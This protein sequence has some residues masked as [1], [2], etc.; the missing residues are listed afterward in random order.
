MI[1]D[2]PPETNA[3]FVRLPVEHAERLGR[4]ASALGAHKKDI[5][6]GLVER[7][8]QPDSQAAMESLR[9]ITPVSERPRRVTIELGERP[10][11][12]GQHSF[13]PASGPEVLTAEQAAELLAVDVD[14][15]L[16][17][18]EHGVLP[19]RRIAGQ[20]RFARQALLAW[21]SA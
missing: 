17:L 18:A 16:E 10:L 13:R 21:L 20:W 9:E 7:Y 5:V 12:V 3:L 1:S 2:M 8:V 15:V 19:G 14:A 11:T 6:A 4:A